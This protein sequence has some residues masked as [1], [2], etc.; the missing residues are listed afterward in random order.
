MMNGHQAIALYVPQSS[1]SCNDP[2]EVQNFSLT[3]NRT[4]RSYINLKA[5]KDY[6]V[7]LIY[8]AYLCKDL[9]STT[10]TYLATNR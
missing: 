2:Y 9:Y 10:V 4:A 7:H 6:T 3:Y 5:F 1:L 8:V